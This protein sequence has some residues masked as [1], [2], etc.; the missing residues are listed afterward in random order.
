MVAPWIIPAGAA[1][2]SGI[3]GLISGNRASDAEKRARKHRQN[4]AGIAGTQ[5]GEY[6]AN[7]APIMRLLAEQAREGTGADRYRGRIGAAGADADLAFG[8]AQ[9]SVDRMLG[10]YGT[11]TGAHEGSL[12]DI[13][14]QRAMA[15]SG[16]MTS[17]RRMIDDEIERRRHNVA[18][19]YASHVGQALGGYQ[20]AAGGE[21]RSAMGHRMRQGENLHAAG[22]LAG[23]ALGA[24]A[25][26]G[27]GGAQAPRPGP[28]DHLG[29]PPIVG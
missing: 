4:L 6:R 13:A 18:Q 2:A 5:W 19:M 3:A 8:Q 16:A 1:A 10:R 9:G 26:M 22:S 14:L 20:A 12:R 17:E 15:K 29:F 7:A 21:D 25:G 23:S 27:Q 24:W 28:F 11:A